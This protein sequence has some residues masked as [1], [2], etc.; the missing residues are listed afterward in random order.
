MLSTLAGLGRS[1]FKWASP[2]L[3]GSPLFHTEI[4][5]LLISGSM[6][7]M[8]GPMLDASEARQPTF[9]KWP[10]AYR[11][12]PLQFGLVNAHLTEGTNASKEWI[13]ARKGR[14]AVAHPSQVVFQPTGGV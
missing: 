13:S 1:L 2:A 10:A 5:L 9:S 8:F 3:W 7:P 4:S 14:D 6:G 11:P 12:D